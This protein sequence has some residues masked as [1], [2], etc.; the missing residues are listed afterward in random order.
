MPLSELFLWQ[1]LGPGLWPHFINFSFRVLLIN[2]AGQSP[3][4]VIMP[5]SVSKVSNA[6]PIP[7]LLYSP[8]PVQWHSNNSVMTVQ[9]WSTASKIPVYASPSSVQLQS[10][11]SPI[12]V[13]CQSNTSPI[14]SN[15]NPNS[16]HSQS[17]AVQY[18]LMSVQV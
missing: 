7:V 12:P 6:R 15:D 13:K 1:D 9:C 2:I 8:M 18:Q 11:A 10:K 16:V 17:H 3:A 4:A 5:S 14:Q